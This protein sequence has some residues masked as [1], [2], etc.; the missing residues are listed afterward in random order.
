MIMLPSKRLSER[1]NPIGAE[2]FVYCL[3][4]FWKTT[5]KKSQTVSCLETNLPGRRTSFITDLF[6]GEKLLLS[7]IGGQL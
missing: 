3:A 1:S 2:Q 4:V 5:T 6:K 7:F